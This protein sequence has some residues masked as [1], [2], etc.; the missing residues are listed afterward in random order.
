MNNEDKSDFIDGDTDEDSTDNSDVYWKHEDVSVDGIIAQVDE[1]EQ[2]TDIV[3]ARKRAFAG[4]DD[5]AEEEQE[6]DDYEYD[7]DDDNDDDDGRVI[8]CSIA[9]IAMT[10]IIEARKREASNKD[11]ESSN[12]DDYT[13]TDKDSDKADDDYS[14]KDK[15]K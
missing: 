13:N 10:D 1:D 9:N 4:E 8:G 3:E 12:D 5:E 7:N 6:D 11:K 14:D 2:K 15:G